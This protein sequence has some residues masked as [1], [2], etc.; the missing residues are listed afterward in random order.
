[1]TALSSGMI[2][3][4]LFGDRF[5]RRFG[6]RVTLWGGALDTAMGALCLALVRSFTL[7]LFSAFLLGIRGSFIQPSAISRRL[8]AAGY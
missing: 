4:G 2:L 6:Q 3:T 7:T 1:M 8:L 5:A